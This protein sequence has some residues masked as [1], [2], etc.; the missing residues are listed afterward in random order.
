MTYTKRN[1]QD[2][3]HAL[4]YTEQKRTTDYQPQQSHSRLNV[5]PIIDLTPIKATDCNIIKIVHADKYM[6]C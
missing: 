4:K 3:K 1:A 5:H 2:W 6:P